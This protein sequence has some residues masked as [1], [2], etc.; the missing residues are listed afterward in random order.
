MKKI[1]AVRYNVRVAVKTPFWETVS[2]FVTSKSPDDE[3]FVA[4]AREK[5]I[6]AT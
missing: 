6:W 4:A 2:C 1:Y 5:H 3:G